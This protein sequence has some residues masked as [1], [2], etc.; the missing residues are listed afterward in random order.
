MQKFNFNY[1]IIGL[2][3][4]LMGLHVLLYVFGQSTLS[5]LFTDLGSGAF[6]VLL[7][8]KIVPYLEELD[9]KFD[10]EDD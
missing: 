10:E 1:L 5:E 6:L 7:G 8:W 3:S 2:G 4:F 9:K